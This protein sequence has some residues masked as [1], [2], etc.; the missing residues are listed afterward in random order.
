MNLTEGETGAALNDLLA[1]RLVQREDGSRV[2]KWRHR[3][4]H[5]LLIKDDRLAVL[6]TLMLRGPQTLSELRSH[7]ET[8]RGPASADGVQAVID[9]LQDRAQPLLQAL[10]R[11][12]GQKEGRFVHTLCGE[13]A[14]VEVEDKPEKSASSAERMA[15]LEAKV[16]ALEARLAELEAR[17]SAV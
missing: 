6:V 13:Q 14:I 17:L 4:G 12:S 8:L 9:D 16:A 11:L 2:P 10:P 1:L 7:G 3:F 15:A 5:E